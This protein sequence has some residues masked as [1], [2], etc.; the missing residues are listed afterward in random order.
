[1]SGVTTGIG[2]CGVD[3][4]AHGG[5]TLDEV[6]AMFANPTRLGA[7][8]RG[9]AARFPDAVAMAGAGVVGLP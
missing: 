6:E 7:T 5:Q 4:G 1:M 8:S 3:A 2:T 9:A